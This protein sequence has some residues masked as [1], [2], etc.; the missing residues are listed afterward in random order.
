MSRWRCGNCAAGSI[1]RGTPGPVARPPKR[2]R[3]A[4]DGPRGRLGAADPGARPRRSRPPLRPNRRAASSTKRR[5]NI[6][7][8][9]RSASNWAKILGL[10]LRAIDEG[11]AELDLLLSLDE[12]GIAV[13][14]KWWRDRRAGLADRLAANAA[15]FPNSSRTSWREFTLAVYRRPDCEARGGKPYPLCAE[16][17]DRFRGRSPATLR[18]NQRIRLYQPRPDRWAG[19]LYGSGLRCSE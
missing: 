6:S 3:I 16:G 2:C 10:V 11:L 14:R 9:T 4:G 8:L 1:W 13:L 5:E 18:L 12:E 17:P 15:A 7:S 19:W